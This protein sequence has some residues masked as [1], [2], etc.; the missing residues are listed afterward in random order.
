M[1]RFNKIVRGQMQPAEGRTSPRQELALVPAAWP[2]GVSAL[3]QAVTACQRRDEGELNVQ[4]RMT[5]AT[6]L[7]SAFCD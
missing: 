6:A 1:E 5:I 7:P 2:A 3:A 4:A